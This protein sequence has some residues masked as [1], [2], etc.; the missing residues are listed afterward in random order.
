MQQDALHQ[1]SHEESVKDLCTRKLLLLVQGTSGYAPLQ[2]YPRKTPEGRRPG[3]EKTCTFTTVVALAIDKDNRFVRVM[4]ASSDVKCLQL[5]YMNM[6]PGR[7]LILSNFK[8]QPDPSGEFD[9]ILNMTENTNYHFQSQL[10]ITNFQPVW[11]RE[12]QPLSAVPIQSA[13]SSAKGLNKWVRGYVVGIPIRFVVEDRYSYMFQVLVLD[14][15]IDGKI[16]RT[17]LLPVRHL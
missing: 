8:I 2:P 10:D 7:A 13:T 15:D 16:C 6:V 11:T 14:R 3:N 9:A 17:T 12:I 4:L 5:G 1:E